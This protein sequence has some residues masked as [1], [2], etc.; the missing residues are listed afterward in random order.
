MLKVIVQIITQDQSQYIEQM[1]EATKG[2]ERIWVADRCIDDTVNKL[3]NLKEN[4]I[5]NAEGEGFL[6]GKMRDLGLD[7]VLSKDY[8]I[9]VMFDGDRI[10]KNLS[11]ELIE[12]EMKN[13]DCSLAYC[14]KDVRKKYFDL[15]HMPAYKNLITAGLIIKTSFLKKVRKLFFMNNRCFYYE[16][17]GKYGEEDLFLGSCLHFLGAKINFSNLVVTG[18]MPSS[19]S[20]FNKINV[21]TREKMIEKLGFL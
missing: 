11:V 12:E 8:D 15:I 2:F 9:V 21:E 17:D 6:A 18:T 7:Y 19:T 3:Q 20:F 14:E 1:I 10:P 5:V 4:V 16:F 13:R